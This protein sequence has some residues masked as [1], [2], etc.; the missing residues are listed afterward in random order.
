MLDC[1]QTNLKM[2]AAW[3]DH[4][5]HGDIVS[6][7][8][9]LSEE[10]AREQPKA[11]PC[12]VLDIERI[13][14]HRYALLA[15]GTTSRRPSNVGYEIHIRKRADYAN[16]GLNEPTK[17]VGRRR[18]LVPLTHSGFV[19]CAANGS[20]VLGSLEGAPLKRL[21]AVRGRIHAERDIAAD[22][23]CQNAPRRPRRPTECAEDFTVEQRS[24]T[25]C[26]VGP[27]VRT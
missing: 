15:Y 11:R 8:F 4:I 13:G 23:R 9:P 3:R 7:R 27:A 18:L 21:N 12:V 10:G 22:R 2:T 5:S 25:R 24:P 14:D 17:F 16:V 1:T 6:F 20:P 26:A 19:I